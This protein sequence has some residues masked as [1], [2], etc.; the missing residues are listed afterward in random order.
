MEEIE[1]VIKDSE[2]EKGIEKRKKKLKDKLFSWVKDNYDKLF[3]VLLIAAFIIRL[4]I[5]LK[6]LNQPLWYDEASYLA[7]AK[8]W[9]LGLDI[10]DIWYYRRG[11]LFPLLYAAFFGLGLGEI[12]IR[13]SMILFSMGVVFVSYFIIRDMFNK[14]IALLSCIGLTFSWILLFFTGRILTDIPAAFLILMA[15]FFFWKGYV[16]KKGNKFVYLFGLFFALAILM[17]MQSIMLL[18]P[19]LIMIFIKERFKMF[20][21]KTLWIT[22]GIFALVMVPQGILY[23]M[24]YGNPVSDIV[25]HYLGVGSE[26]VQKGEQRVISSAIFNYFK[27][28]PYM[29]SNIMLILLIIGTGYFLLDLILGF[30]Q[31]FKNEDLQ[32]KFFVFCWILSLFLIMGYIGS[33]SYVEHRY[34]TAGLPFLFL[35]SAIPLVKLSDFFTKKFKMKEF[36]SIIIVSLILIFLMVVNIFGASNYTTTFNLLEN[37]KT[38]YLEVQQAGLWLKQYS[39]PQDIIISNSQ[40]QIQYYSERSTYTIDEV[41]KNQS[42]F[43]ENITK[44]NPKYFMLSSFEPHEQWMYSYPQEHNNTLIPVQVYQQNE[45]PVVIIYGFNY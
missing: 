2:S 7:S 8:K 6:T 37:K 4:I 15:L 33:V 19:F 9:G 35:L 34:I 40:P 21:N 29:M 12:S 18:P 42:A 22:L 44:L 13:F 11:F 5:F 1:G 24:H 32:N 43:Q 41:G 30:D 25:S 16:L 27:D 38:S 39:N 45:Q 17:R 3:I 26:A 10:R 23:F 20:K 31:I 14:K 28:L 36:S